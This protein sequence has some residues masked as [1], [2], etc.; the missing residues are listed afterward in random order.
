MQTVLLNHAPV[1][2][3]PW[4]AVTAQTKYFQRGEI[5]TLDGASVQ[6]SYQLLAG[7]VVIIRQGRPV[8]LI[9]AGEWLGGW[10]WPD[11]IA[12]AWRD[13]VLATND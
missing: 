2:A 4:P 9:E 5:I 10:G 3:V 1:Q 8:D 12:V 11:A 6:R 13:S 7:E